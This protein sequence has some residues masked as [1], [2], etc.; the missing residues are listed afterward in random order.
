M[1]ENDQHFILQK[2]ATLHGGDYVIYDVLG[3]G[4]FG[5]T[6]LAKQDML[7]K[8][9]AIKEFFIQTLCARDENSK[10]VTLTQADMVER[11]RQKFVKEAQMMAN[12]NHPCI[13][14]VVSVFEENNT[15]YYVME[16]IKGESLKDKVEKNGPMPEQMA[17][18]YITKVAE[19]LDYIH[20]SQ[21]NHLDIKPANIMVQDED[22][23]PILVDFGISKQYDEKKNQTSTTPPGVSYGYSPIEQYRP[24]GVS[25]FSPQA[26]IYA[27][28][29]TLYKLLTG[30]TPPD[31]SDVFNYGLTSLP[32][33]ISANVR[34]AIIMAMQPRVGDRPGSMKEFIAM[35]GPAKTTKKTDRKRARPSRGKACIGWV[36]GGM[37][38]LALVAMFLVWQNEKEEEQIR[39]ANQAA[40]RLE[41]ATKQ[42]EEA[43]K[44][45]EE[46]AKQLEEAK[47]QAATTTT[48][49][50]TTTDYSYE[51]V[52]P[53]Y[54]SPALPRGHVIQ[55]GGYTNVRSGPGTNYSI[56]KKIK[57]G[58]PIYYTVYNSKWCVVYN[59]NG[60]AIGYMY[61]SK[62]IK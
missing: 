48:T 12:L 13:V 10:V 30:K 22:D 42:N 62:V 54:S 2:G 24:G 59:D 23:N 39:K 53:Q 34:E 38:L 52:E 8:T 60:D 19:A 6:Y 17:L 18:R 40:R 20:N 21:I 50:T 46:A 61:S 27:L 35:L 56:V 49:T 47:A 51:E 33:T 4:G 44:R 57:D 41:A 11:Y 5:I 25:T 29:A 58:S 15:V 7:N 3:Q 37:V 1:Q 14:K 26:D 43:A 55:E 16:Y 36:L 45:N 28:G 31:A 9:F 32:N